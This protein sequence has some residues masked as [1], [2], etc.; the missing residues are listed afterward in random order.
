MALEHQNDPDLIRALLMD[1]GTWVVVG[2]SNNTDRPAHGVAR[3]LGV[4]RGKTIVPVHP[5]AETVDGAQGYASLAD[6][7]DQ[8]VTVV[9]C[10]VSSE[11]VGAVIDDAIAQRDRLRIEAIW[12]QLAV[13]DEEAAARAREAGLGVIMDT[14]PVIEWRAAEREGRQP[15]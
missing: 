14:C 2:L 6:V 10:F 8:D 4:E 13:V 9:D 12:T 15:T 3:W 7:P 1:P 11:H 5:R